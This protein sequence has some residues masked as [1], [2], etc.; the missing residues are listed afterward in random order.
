[1]SPASLAVFPHHLS[2]EAQEDVSINWPRIRQRL[3]CFRRCRRHSN[4]LSIICRRQRV[5][6][7]AAAVRK[8]S[9][10]LLKGCRFPLNLFMAYA[11]PCK[12]HSS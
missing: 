5:L 3:L 8:C 2:S 6:T 7:G 1:M 9:V 4:T 11:C 10:V 12:V